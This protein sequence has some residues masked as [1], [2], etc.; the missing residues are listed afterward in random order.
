MEL[1]IGIIGV[2]LT[3]WTIKIQFYS[4]PKKELEH[5]ILLFN[6]TQKLSL[7]VQDELETLIVQYNGWE[8]EML[9]NFTYRT[10]LEEMKA[11]FKTNLTDDVLKNILSHSLSKSTILSLTQSLENQQNSLI[12]LQANINLVRRQMT[13]DE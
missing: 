12:Q 8:C 4:T 1:V 13:N 7:Q 9:P 5:M 11:S 2:L 10:C 3:L 6:S